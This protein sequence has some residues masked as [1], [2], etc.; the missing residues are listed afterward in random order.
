MSKF[1]F[2]KNGKIV[3]KLKYFISRK[4]HKYIKHSI[5]K[6]N[7]DLKNSYVN[8]KCYLLGN[9][10]S[11]NNHDLLLLENENVFCV[12]TFFVHKC[13][14]KIK[15]NFYVFA[16]PDLYNLV[17]SNKDWWSKLIENAS[18]KGIC[19]F[20]PIQLK[21]TYVHHNLINEKIYFIDFSKRFNEKSVE[22][23]DLTHSING[24][25]NVLILT[26]QIA[27]YLG[28]NEIYLLGAD[29]DWLSHFGNEQRHFYDTKVTKVEN[30]GSDNYP[31]HWWLDAVNKMFNQYKLINNHIDKKKNIKIFNASESGVLD[32]FPLIRYKDTFENENN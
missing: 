10:P 5:L 12:N 32:I 23:F 22:N 30:V 21:N 8:Q 2:S 28:F 6:N 4:K 3:E 31:Y 27:M 20:L 14:Q 16:D 7:R 25:Q 29:H 17:D 19:F 1:L 15:P 9:A 18:G 26:I 13:F 24:V 11:L